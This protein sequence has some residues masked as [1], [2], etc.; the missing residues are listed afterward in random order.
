MI[1]ED[2]GILKQLAHVGVYRI[3]IMYILS[4][5]NRFPRNQDLQDYGHFKQSLATV[6]SIFNIV[7]R[8]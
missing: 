7:I 8:Q 6:D 4:I 1:Y 5:K 3:I 2:L